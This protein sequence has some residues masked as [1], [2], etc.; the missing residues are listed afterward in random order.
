VGIPFPDAVLDLVAHKVPPP[1]SHEAILK[2]TMRDGADCVARGW[3]HRFAPEGACV[4]EA[5]LLASEL[6]QE[7]PY[8]YAQAK[9]RLNRHAL[10]Q[11]GSF[12]RDGAAAWVKDLDHPD[13]KAALGRTLAKLARR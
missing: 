3:A 13:T 11:F 5:V 7:S 10:A 12:V 6:G 1:E 9:A 8:A 2:G 4:D